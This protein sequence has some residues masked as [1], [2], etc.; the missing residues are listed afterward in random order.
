MSK[1]FTY[2]LALLCL[3]SSLTLAAP[4]R[5]A[6]DKRL[7]VKPR[8]SHD[9]IAN[10]QK[11]KRPDG[12]GTE[13]RLADVSKAKSAQRQQREKKGLIARSAVISS[14]QNWTLVPRE[15]VLHV[16]AA[17]NKRVNDQRAGKL[18]GWQQFY[19]KNRAWIKVVP[20]TI[21]QASGEKPL[22][23]EYL[24]SLKRTG[25]VVVAV[26]KGGPI[27]VKF[28]VEPAAETAGGNKRPAKGS[29]SVGRLSPGSSRVAVARP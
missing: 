14:N 16:P 4:E 2:T 9:Q 26:C 13:V 6:A 3:G 21:E 27:S 25:Q 17:Y 29:Q 24:D 15:A 22:T 23:K 10:K 1:N 7:E 12:K 28:P 8:P 19:G 5:V 20:V 11:L 18:V